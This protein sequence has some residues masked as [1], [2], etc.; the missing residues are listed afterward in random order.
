MPPILVLEEEHA[1][2]FLT[3]ALSPI[4]LPRSGGV[5]V[6]GTAVRVSCTVVCG[7][8]LLGT[9]LNCSF[10]LMSVSAVAHRSGLKANN[11]GPLTE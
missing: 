10:L 4:G 5:V 8:I 1:S 2:E 6:L 9:L 7:F 11:N 3:T